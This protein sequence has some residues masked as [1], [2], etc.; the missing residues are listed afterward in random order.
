M[1]IRLK[2]IRQKHEQI[3]KIGELMDMF[4]VNPSYY[5]YQPMIGASSN[6]TSTIDPKIE[7]T[8]ELFQ[9]FHLAR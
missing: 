4:K 1:P 9:M 3:R 7:K 6:I 8:R 2:I 5:Q